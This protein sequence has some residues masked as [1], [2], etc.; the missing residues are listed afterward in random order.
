M[1]GN[2]PWLCWRGPD[3]NALFDYV[4]FDADGYD[5]VFLRL[6]GVIYSVVHIIL[7]YKLCYTILI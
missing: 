3:P 1:V 5:A 7:S 4:V 6:Y 2:S